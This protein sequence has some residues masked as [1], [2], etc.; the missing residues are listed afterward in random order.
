[1]R[2]LLIR[3]S[4]LVPIFTIAYLT[5]KISE[6]HL[7]HWVQYNLDSDLEGYARW[8]VVSW[9]FIGLGL[10]ALIWFW[11]STKDED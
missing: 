2:K 8:S 10:V 5:Q 3:A 9:V 11:V 4:L 7:T 1:M 6:L